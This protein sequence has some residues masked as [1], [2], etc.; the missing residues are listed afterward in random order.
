MEAEGANRIKEVCFVC[1]FAFQSER[2]LITCLHANGNDPVER[3]KLKRK[4]HRRG[5]FQ[6]QGS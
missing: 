6:L 1:L 5:K 3:G 4:Q 2:L